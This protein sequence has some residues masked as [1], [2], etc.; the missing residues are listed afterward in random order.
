MDGL[1]TGS[2]AVNGGKRHEGRDALAQIDVEQVV[3]V[4]DVAIEHTDGVLFLILIGPLR[5]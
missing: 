5:G 1:S 3:G 4:D 2:A